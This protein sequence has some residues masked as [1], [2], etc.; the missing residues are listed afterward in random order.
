M[1]DV[2]VIRIVAINSCVSVVRIIPARKQTRMTFPE[3]PKGTDDSVPVRLVVRSVG[4]IVVGA[5]PK[6]VVRRGPVRFCRRAASVPRVNDVPGDRG[7]DHRRTI[8]GS[9]PDFAFYAW[10]VMVR[11]FFWGSAVGEI[12]ELEPGWVIPVIASTG[13]R[14]V[15]PAIDFQAALMGAFL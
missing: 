10:T 15:H 4:I 8:A 12:H 11:G 3:I 13:L 7:T 9:H 14:R 5:I 2:P 1:S 6:V